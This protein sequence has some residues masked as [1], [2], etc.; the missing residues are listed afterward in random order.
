MSN[1]SAAAAAES[2]IQ[3]PKR[4]VVLAHMD[5]DHERKTVRLRDHSARNQQ[6]AQLSVQ[7][8]A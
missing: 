8:R 6:N 4:H 7:L 2:A 5:D 3:T 1:V